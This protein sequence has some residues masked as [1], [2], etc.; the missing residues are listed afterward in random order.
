MTERLMSRDDIEFMAVGRRNLLALRA[1]EMKRLLNEIIEIIDKGEYESAYA[2][3]LLENVESFSNSR[4]QIINGI[5]Q[6]EGK[7][8]VD[9]G[10]HG[11]RGD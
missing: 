11:E 8:D 10:I 1:K 3:K 5:R 6:L 4:E 9:R 2:G 7:C